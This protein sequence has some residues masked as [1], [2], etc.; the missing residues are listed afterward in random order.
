MESYFLLLNYKLYTIY[1][2]SLSLSVFFPL[3]HFYSLSE[4]YVGQQQEA[5]KEQSHGQVTVL[6][7]EL[8]TY[9]RN[10]SF[11]ITMGTKYNFII[12]FKW[13]PQIENSF[14]FRLGA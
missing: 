10:L 2:Y 4:S 5:G 13:Q 8:P 9:E 11:Y 14:L 6:S 1:T 7:T 3:S 12:I